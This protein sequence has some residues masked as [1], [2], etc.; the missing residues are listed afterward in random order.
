ME[1]KKKLPITLVTGFLG[2]GKTQLLRQWIMDH[3]ELKFGLVENEFGKGVVEQ[4]RLSQDKI[5]WFEST[6]GCLCCQIQGD[7]IPLLKKM[8]DQ[9]QVEQLD[10]LFIETTGLADPAP[11]IQTLLSP[12]PWRE[13]FEL[14]HAFTVIDGFFFEKQF[15]DLGE[16]SE[17]IRQILATPMAV[18]SKTDLITVEKRKGITQQILELNP[19]IEIVDNDLTF[20]AI[21]NK[22]SY[23]LKTIENDWTRNFQLIKQSSAKSFSLN[24]TATTHGQAPHQHSDIQTFTIEVEGELDPRVFELFLNVTFAQNPTGILRTKGILAFQNQSQK[25]LF[26]GVYDRFEFDLGRDWES[27][28]IKLN[29]MVIIGAKTQKELW[30]KG[31][32]NCL[33]RK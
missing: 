21:Q 3:P 2:A 17:L 16:N 5:E 26:Q 24:R 9:N 12:G 32:Q 14:N 28:D 31:L 25:V 11:L 13:S 20:A 27:S 8:I 30:Q 4:E 1:I 19:E 6:E 7:L 23:S 29:Q 22:R 10:H 18:L 33:A 15:Q